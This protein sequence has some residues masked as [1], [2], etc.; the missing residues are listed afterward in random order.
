MINNPILNLKNGFPNGMEWTQSNI[1]SGL[2]A[3]VY[4]ANGIWVACCTNTNSGL[5]YST[6]G[7][8]WTKSNVTVYMNTTYNAN[9][10]W[11]VASDNGGGLYYS[12]DG[13][14]WTQSN[15][16][17]GSFDSVYNA[18]GIWVSCIYS[19]DTNIIYYSTDGKVWTQSNM[20]DGSLS[21]VYNANGMWVAAIKNKGLY[22]S[23]T[24]EP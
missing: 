14:T 19:R 4:N 8:T 7:K 13:K 12:T 11:V 22:Y 9:G 24:W 15:M 5:F 3:Y 16:T 21:S 20:T 2:F 17:T 18:N 23:V 10:I 6:D 1:T